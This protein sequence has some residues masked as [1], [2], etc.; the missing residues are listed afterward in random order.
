[1]LGAY[2]IKKT[3]LPYLG[4]HVQVPDL[5][6]EVVS[7]YHVAARVGELHVGDGRDDLGEEA[8][9]RRVLGLLEH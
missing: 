6:G 7:G 3:I 2:F 9:V 5:D 1:M 8:A 4:L